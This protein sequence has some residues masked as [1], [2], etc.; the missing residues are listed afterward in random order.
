M[1]LPYPKDDGLR[2]YVCF[3]CGEKFED[4]TAFNAHIKELHEEGRDYVLCPLERCQAPIRDVKMHFK[5]K[6]PHDEVPKAG[7][8]RS[9]IWR[10]FGGKK[11]GKMRIRKPTFREG[12]LVSTK[13]EGKEF[14]YKS[15][16]E[17]QVLECLEVIPE[18]LRYD[19]EP[20]KGGIPYLFEGKIH[21]YFPDLFIYF[22]DGHAEIWEIKPENQ[23][24][25]PVNR[26]KW[27]S[28]V[29]Y[30][31]S[32]GWRFVVINEGEISKLKTLARN[33]RRKQVS[34]HEE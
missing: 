2:K 31:E 17:C 15:G 18:V 29:L 9:I 22:D 26:A 24:D 25:L 20:I 27:D 30:C 19:Y 5:A 13:N 1:T 4:Y 8:L 11:G 21:H 16:Y 12:Y 34:T 14:H 28:A 7:A 32:K 23:N 3:V 6:H 10:D 33:I